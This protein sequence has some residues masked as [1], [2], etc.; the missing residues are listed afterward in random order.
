VKSRFL[1]DP[2]RSAQIARSS[3]ATTVAS[4]HRQVPGPAYLPSW[5]LST[6]P[7]LSSLQTTGRAVL[8]KR[9]RTGAVHAPIARP[10]KHAHLAIIDGG[11]VPGQPLAPPP[12]EVR[13]K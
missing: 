6:Q 8:I 9:F 1:T 2:S 12:E 4:I 5:R 7:R 10:T 11:L 3:A 13:T